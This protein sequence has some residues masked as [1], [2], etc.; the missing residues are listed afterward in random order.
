MCLPRGANS[1]FGEGAIGVH[2]DMKDTP[3][4]VD[5]RGGPQCNSSRLADALPLVL[6]R[7]CLPPPPPPL[8]AV[9]TAQPCA[10]ARAE[11]WSIALA[12]VVPSARALLASMLAALALA[13]LA[14]LSLSGVPPPFLPLLPITFFL[15]LVQPRLKSEELL[16]EEEDNKELVKLVKERPS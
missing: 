6:P 1:A 7:L 3:D 9:P 8:F 13:A 4:H 10:L 12:S 14:L 16:E 11:I 15:S 2:V 5:P